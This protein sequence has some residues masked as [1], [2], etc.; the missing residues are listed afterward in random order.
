MLIQETKMQK[1]ESLLYFN[2][3]KSVACAD[4]RRKITFPDWRSFKGKDEQG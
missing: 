1:C 3:D 4:V 2:P